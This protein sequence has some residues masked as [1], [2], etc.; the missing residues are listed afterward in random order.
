[1]TT[2]AMTVAT[3]TTTTTTGGGRSLEAR[4]AALET[5]LGGKSA[6]NEEADVATRLSRLEASAE[7]QL[8]PSFRSLWK[9][10]LALLDELHPGL[11]LT[12]Q[13]QPLLYKRQHVLAA[14]DSLGNDMG[15]LAKLLPLLSLNSNNTTKDAFIREDQV[16][17]APIL[18]S[19]Q[20]V[21]SPE[22]QR[23]LDALR[24][25]LDEAQSKVQTL[26]KQFQHLLESY[27]VLVT[28]MSEKCIL[29]DEIISG[30]ET[31]QENK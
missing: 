30:K 17:Q 8:D 22:D 6:P 29:A 25:T 19:S 2:T 5:K 27:H 18:T 20:F 1:M 12:H 16:T 21:I 10:S 23:R 26:T 14:S 4:L 31:K 15:E 13:Q 24:M 11:G 7:K 3:I 9:E 28:A